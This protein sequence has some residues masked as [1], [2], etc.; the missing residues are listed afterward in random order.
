MGA[1]VDSSG[2]GVGDLSQTVSQLADS[3]LPSIATAGAGAVGAYLTGE[4]VKDLGV[5]G[6]PAQ[7]IDTGA[8]FAVG[9]IASNLTSE[10][11][12]DTS[13]A[14]DSGLTIA[15]FADVFAGFA[16]AEI[17]SLV[18]SWDTPEEEDLAAVGATVGG[19]LGS[20]LGPVGTFIGG[21]L[22]DMFGGLIGGLFGGP[23]NPWTGGTIIVATNSMNPFAYVQT[24]SHDNGPD[25][26]LA[27][28]GNAISTELN[29]IVST[30]GA[31][32]ANAQSLN[33]ALFLNAQV[34]QRNIRVI[35]KGQATNFNISDASHY[36]DY[37][38]FDQLSQIAFNGGDV[39][40]ERAINATV[41][42]W[43]AFGSTIT[44]NTLLGNIQVAK[45]YEK[46][47]QNEATING[48]IAKN[49]TSDFSAGWI[50]EL[51]QAVAL[52][53]AN[54]VTQPGFS[55]KYGTLDYYGEVFNYGMDAGRIAATIESFRNGANST[56]NTSEA[57]LAR[58]LGLPVPGNWYP[59]L[60]TENKI[61]IDGSG[62][63]LDLQESGLPLIV[64]GDQF[65]LKIA[66][67]SNNVTM[68]GQTEFLSIQGDGSSIIENGDFD[69]VSI[70]GNGNSA[71]VNGRQ[72]TILLSG[73]GNS[74][75]NANGS[76]NV[77]DNSNVT[78]NGLQE[79]V[80]VW[81]HSTLLVN[82]GQMNVSVNG[83]GSSVTLNGDNEQVQLIGDGD[84]LINNGQGDTVTVTGTNAS[85]TQG[86]GSV[87]VADWVTLS[88]NG[89]YFG[90][91]AG[92]NDRLT[93]GGQY[94]GVTL[95]GQADV[96]T[97][98]GMSMKISGDTFD[99]SLTSNGNNNSIVVSG[100]ANTV[101][102]NGG[103][104]Y[105]TA[106]GDDNN[107]ISNGQS[108]TLEAIGSGNS[109]TEN[110][111]QGFMSAN[112]NG[113]V[114][115]ANGQQI[116][117]AMAGGNSNV[118]IGNGKVSYATGATGVL[119]GIADA[120]SLTSA[121]DLTVN[122]GS[123]HVSLNGTLD[124]V[125]ANGD[126]NIINI[127]GGN[128]TLTANGSGVTI[129]ASGNADGMTLNGNRD[130]LSISGDGSAFWINGQQN[131][132]TFGGTNNTVHS[133]GLSATVLDSS[134]AE[135]DGGGNSVTLSN[136]DTVTLN[137]SG[138]VVNETDTNS[139]A[140]INGDYENATT[141]G[142]GNSLVINGNSS[143]VVL[144]GE[145]NAV[146]ISGLAASIAASGVEQTITDNQGNIAVAAG[147][148]VNLVGNGSI[149]TLGNA[150]S[151]TV[152]GSN[153]WVNATSD[154]SVTMTGTGN[155]IGGLAVGITAILAGD[156]QFAALDGD[157]IRIEGGI[158]ANVSGSGNAIRADQGAVVT[159]DGT[160]NAL[161]MTG[162]TLV[163]AD[164]TAET[165]SDPETGSS[166]SGFSVDGFDYTSYKAGEFSSAAGQTS[167]QSLADTGANSVSLVVT[168]YVN[169]ITDTDIEP[170]AA[171]E[172]DA[173]LEQAIANAKAAGL[174]V[175]LKPH[176]D[177][178]DGTWRAYLAPSNVAHFF[179]NYQAMIVHY[180][181]IAQATGAGMLVIGTE[182]ESLSGSAYEPYWDA[183]ISAVRQVYS[184]K[185]TY[186]SGWN[187]TANVSFW[188]KLD[189]IGADAYIPVTSHIDPTLQQLETGWTTVSS[190]PAAASAMENMSPLA[191][192]Q[193]ISAE[194]DKSVLFTEIG[195]QSVNDTNQLEGAFG[196]SNWVD[197][198]QQSR[199]LQAFFSTFSQ[200]GGNWFEGAYLWN[201][202]ANPADVGANDFTV[203]GKP[204]L[205]IVDF[206][207]G[208]QTG[209]ALG[210]AT[211]NSLNGDS[212]MIRVGSGDALNVTGNDN[213][214]SLGSNAAVVVNG[215]GNT[216]AVTGGNNVIETSGATMISLSRDGTTVITS[217]DGDTIVAGGARDGL[218]INSNGS[219][220][221]L[222]GTAD[223]LTLSG[224]GSTI[225]V[226]GAADTLSVA[227]TGNTVNVSGN[228]AVIQ[229][230]GANSIELV[231]NGS[232]AAVEGG[233]DTIDVSGVGDSISVASSGATIVVGDVG[234]TIALDSGNYQI[235]TGNGN[236]SI[237]AGDGSNVISV[238][239]GTN[240]ISLGNGNNAVT[241]GD[242]SDTVTL[243]S[244]IDAITLGNGN[245]TLTL[246]GND[247]LAVDV[248]A[249][250]STK[251]AAALILDGSS[252]SSQSNE[253]IF[254]RAD[255]DQVWFSRSNNDLLVSVIGTSS[256]ID[257]AGWFD[258]NT[259]SI[260][261]FAA[262]DG[263]VLTGNDV[264][265]LVSAMASFGPPAA[266][267]TTLPDSYQNQL[268]PVIAA[269]W[270]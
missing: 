164:Q 165:G 23:P 109:L 243:G 219:T 193:G 202:D 150:D 33:R 138:Y 251:A 221:T 124:N 241:L 171:T 36:V 192:Y 158:H 93:V 79:S 53:L 22:G 76:A 94:I 89:E 264:D 213:Q 86:A 61:K 116:T 160:S 195:Y 134:S 261:S 101:T 3:A 130:S 115:H 144:S 128:D 242:G 74:L 266:G 1:I 85:L 110:G 113:N 6:L 45:D 78:I 146:T 212:D 204:A 207:Y 71:V 206:W 129:G 72:A 136:N 263:K 117:V 105:V 166:R 100:N 57:G 37:V 66:G 126:S 179:A 81:N 147:S 209:S 143:N 132:A 69:S 59:N 127:R 259:T 268:H 15:N 201:W 234:S 253:L 8:G 162:G 95:S 226:V 246:G 262:A 21:F 18:A 16:G 11:L 135:F 187:E 238:G 13:V 191:F 140:T 12:G 152:E 41:Q 27:S 107:L 248:A 19:A 84:S 112:G 210:T 163:L 120:I 176:L 51:Q 55:S 5:T 106:S 258:G 118:T 224:N 142:N 125:T 62:M 256:Q 28:I 24:L 211:P 235:A 208:K 40:V 269:N 48:L 200:N 46:Y 255:S 83:S 34:P 218:A 43:Q 65:Q 184:G 149:A 153:N 228:S 175:T 29:G 39:F 216:V 121:S 58:D 247:A 82:G 47:L 189:V 151:L 260:Q 222:A 63:L 270:H 170:A 49:P 199:A 123:M 198:Q 244:G 267:S 32:V 30:V 197:F 44:L 31:T 215:Q 225:N 56:P 172:S 90:V 141:G 25:A 168:Q 252:A 9:T 68:N 133:S 50:I 148:Q 174:S 77:A 229:T 249:G 178:A 180:A 186:A 10:A 177:V 159:V 181:E 73:G 245:D 182:M 240:S 254:G 92:N 157:T 257:I 233:S 108:F 60:G 230:N 2:A 139:A 14:W 88:A 97:T 131:V 98:N 154:D 20:V 217:G 96:V 67:N 196:T 17:A 111:D 104:G 232:S 75:T 250:D 173:S 80:S 137:G 188:S 237:T 91:Q 103:G 185:L 102:G 220:V 87:N 64:N 54:G 26:Y 214:I 205:N 155:G 35:E 223:A 38:V 169:N 119:N 265:A 161:Q 42:Q 183:L 203:Q 122:G 7:V 194:Y 231:G 239:A 145:S 52:N 190:D 4:L 236:N 70:F 114:V 156:G 227:G 167:M 99:S